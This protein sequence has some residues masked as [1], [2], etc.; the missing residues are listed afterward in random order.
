VKNVNRLW[1]CLLLV[2]G[3]M[4]VAARAGAAL[5]EPRTT[6]SGYAIVTARTA[7]VREG[8]SPKAAVITIVE[9]GEVFAKI[10]RTGGWYFLQISDGSQGWVSGRAL[11]RYD[12]AEAPVGEVAPPEEG[13]VAEPPESPVVPVYPP[14]IYQ[15]PYPYQYP[16]SYQYPYGG[17]YFYS[18]WYIYDRDPFW[19]STWDRDRDRHRDWDRDRDR[20]RSR[21]RS[22][23]GG[24]TTTVRPRDDDHRSGMGSA[25]HPVA[26]RLPRPFRR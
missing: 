12:Q 16:Y 7:E 9:Q 4:C 25:P 20:D 23:T 24:G 15:Y 5:V 21:E 14:T 2:T 8:P 18:E 6:E 1:W 13:A 17:P 26:P 22:S 3:L 10:G 11:R 19:H